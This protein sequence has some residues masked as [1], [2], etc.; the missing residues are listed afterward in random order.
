M[1][2]HSVVYMLIISFVIFLSALTNP[3]SSSAQEAN[4]DLKDIL[5]GFSKDTV[6]IPAGTKMEVGKNYLSFLPVV[7]YGPAFGFLVGGALSLNK[8]L[9]ESPTKATNALINF[10]V[11]TKNQF[12]LNAR[13]KIYLDQNKWF[14]QG[15][16][17]FLLYA[18]P[19]YGLGINKTEADKGI[20]S[21]PGINENTPISEEPMKYSQVRFYEEAAVKLGESSFYAG[22]G[23]AIDQHFNIQDQRLDTIPTSPSYFITSHNSYSKDKNFNPTHY[24]TNGIKLSVLTDTRDNIA[25]PYK[26]YFFSLSLLNN[27]KIGSNSKQSTQLLY[28]GRYYLG[29]NKARPR[30]VLTFWSFGTFLLAGTMPYLAL[31]SIGWDTYNR[32]GRGF[33]QGRYRGLSMV[34]NE[35]EY[36]FPISKNN[37]FGGSLF[38]NATNASS[39]NQQLFDRTALGYG[40]GLRLQM[41]KAAR[42]NITVDFGMTGKELGGVYFNLQEAF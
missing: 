41:D 33:V 22:L 24:G 17:R 29:V 21:N 32:S 42:V 7:G 6:P 9:G 8:L 2:S 20:T 19:T 36:R 40:V 31:P 4:K 16:W 10:Q 5:R 14:I 37:F 3:N 38:A 13:S 39:S 1:K 18:Q 28:D 26:G 34:Y 15:D 12:I 35:A 25:N 11:T 30:Q 23:V 27:L